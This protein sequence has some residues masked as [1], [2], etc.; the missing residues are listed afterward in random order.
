MNSP[1]PRRLNSVNNGNNNNNNNSSSGDL[2]GDHG[3]PGSPNS[4][5]YW[6]SRLNTLKNS[7]LGTPRFHRRKM[8]SKFPMNFMP[9]LVKTEKTTNFF[10]ISID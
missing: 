5:P 2:L 3:Q 8:Q 9:G 7:F 10:F 1:K 4:Q 6:K